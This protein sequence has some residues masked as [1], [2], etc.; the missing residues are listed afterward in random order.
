[1]A[2]FEFHMIATIKCCHF[3]LITLFKL[4]PPPR[5]AHVKFHHLISGEMLDG[6]ELPPPSLHFNQQHIFTVHYL[7]VQ[8]VEQCRAV[9][10]G[11]CDCDGVLGTGIKSQATPSQRT[12]LPSGGGN[13]IKLDEKS[14]KLRRLLSAALDNLR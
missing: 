1:M 3:I 11:V 10:C 2:T 5:R 6:C 13:R 7:E 14:R 12:H 4:E 9:D 8:I